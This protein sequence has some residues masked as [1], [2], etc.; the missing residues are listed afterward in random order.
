MNETPCGGDDQSSEI[1]SWKW[2]KRQ[3]SDFV[4]HGVCEATTTKL[5]RSVFGPHSSLLT[6]SSFMSLSKTTPLPIILTCV[7]GLVPVGRLDPH[8]MLDCVLWKKNQTVSCHSQ[9]DWTWP[10]KQSSTE[11]SWER[12]DFLF[13]KGN[14]YSVSPTSLP[15]IV[16]IL[17]FPVSPQV[18]SSFFSCY[19][20][21]NIQL[22]VLFSLPR[23]SFQ[24]F[25][26][27]FYTDENI[28]VCT[29]YR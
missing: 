10:G 18:P 21:E 2:A 15:S 6:S 14:V 20:N 23:F 9:T 28:R 4:S 24:F 27:K 25:F 11:Y 13:K 19:Q 5:S 12:L 8:C 26:Q 29:N 7:S 3:A 16:F 22:K 1:T 17:L